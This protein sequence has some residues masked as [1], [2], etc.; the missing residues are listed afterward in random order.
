VITGAKKRSQTDMVRRAVDSVALI[1]RQRGESAANYRTPQAA[2]PPEPAKSVCVHTSIRSPSAS[3]LVK[4][5]SRSACDLSAMAA[6]TPAVS[7]STLG[8]VANHGRLLDR[9]SYIRFFRAFL[10]SQRRHG[11]NS[12]VVDTHRFLRA[13]R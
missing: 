3:S 10:P 12:S 7:Y 2:Q 13:V 11:S 9:R 5:K 1:V 6:R 8:S 4:D